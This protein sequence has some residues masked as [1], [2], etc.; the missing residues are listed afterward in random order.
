MIAP[1]LITP[2]SCGVKLRGFERRTFVGKL[3]ENREF[4]HDNEV[5][6]QRRTVISSLYVCMAIKY[7]IVLFVETPR[8]F[9]TAVINLRGVST[10][11]N[12]YKGVLY[13]TIF[14][15]CTLSC[16]YWVG[17]HWW[18]LN[19]F[20]HV[21]LFMNTDPN[22]CPDADKTVRHETIPRLCPYAC[23]QYEVHDEFCQN[24]RSERRQK[25]EDGIWIQVSLFCP[26]QGKDLGQH[27]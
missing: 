27:S 18:F 7:I 23:V 8:K 5:R 6:K 3:L 14:P 10:K 24:I 17:R 19:V 2:E 15:A 9:I 26:D 11:K 21:S 4:E 16:A 13:L 22:S 1:C 12:Y 25:N 20:S